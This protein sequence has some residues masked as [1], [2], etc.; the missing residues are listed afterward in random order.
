[1]NFEL[2]DEQK[3]LK[4]TVASFVRKESPVERFRKLRDNPLGYDRAVWRKMGDLGW[5]AIAFDE[6]VGG[7]GGNL[8]D[9]ALILEQ[10]GTALVPEP[11][12]E[13]VIIAGSLLASCGSTAQ[14]E[15]WLA[16]MIAGETTLAFAWIEA[17][18]R[19]DP[20]SVVLR[21]DPDG[22]GYRLDGQKR[23]VRNGHAADQIVV[24]ARCP[25]GLTLFVVD[26]KSDGLEVTPVN[27]FDG[28]RAAL[29]AFDAVRLSVDRRLGAPG[30]A[31]SAVNWALD[32][33]AAAACA[34]GVGVMQT[35][36]RLTLDYLKTREQFGS[37]IGSFQALQHRSVDMFV[38]T[39]LARSA[40]LR[41]VIRADESDPVLRGTAVSAAKVQ[42]ATAGRFVT[43]QGIQLHGGIGVTDE[44]D[45]G[46]YFKRMHALNT[47]YGD[48]LHHLQRFASLPT[49][50]EALGG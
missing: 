49:F 42:L 10:F 6:A 23:F 44:A 29:L 17:Q 43:Q 25:E 20:E 33:A 13:S 18:V 15:R 36:L 46:L 30:S 11:F 8:V 37:K 9:A 14:Q 2:T 28:Q 26:G 4:Q 16:P 21:A 50:E 47:C 5:L 39:E 27:C 12:I 32:K 38:E 41:A 48:E 35:T 34:E 24:L 22:D 3:Q 40:M 19:Y 45:V 31:L 7:L 1:M